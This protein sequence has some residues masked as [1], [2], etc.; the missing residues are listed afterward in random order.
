MHKLVLVGCLVSFVAVAGDEKAMGAD[1]AMG[2]EKTMMDW[3]PRKVTKEDRKGVEAA[4]MAYHKAWEAGDLATAMGMVD[5]PIYMMTDD[6]QG[7][8]LAGTWDKAMWEKEMAP[9]MKMMSENKDAMKMVGKPKMTM[10]FLSDTMAVVTST[11]KMQMGKATHETRGSMLVIQKDGKW[12]L[13]GEMASGWGDMGGEPKAEM[14]NIQDQ[15]Q[16]AAAPEK[17]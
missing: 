12:M 16:A 9:A 2:G 8:V 6:S 5:F 17:K 11:G 15:K 13:K 10:F 7:K 3:K 4:L 14:L 1:K